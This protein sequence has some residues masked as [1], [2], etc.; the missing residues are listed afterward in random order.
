MEDDFIKF[1]Q[2]KYLRR[3]LEK[4]N[5][6]TAKQTL[7]FNYITEIWEIFQVHVDI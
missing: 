2:E 4:V 7:K 1:Y 5:A 6:T 3:I